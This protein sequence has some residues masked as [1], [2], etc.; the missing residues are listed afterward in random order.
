M[1][2][3]FGSDA[4]TAAVRFPLSTSVILQQR[5]VM[6]GWHERPE[7]PHTCPSELSITRACHNRKRLG[8]F[9]QVAKPSAAMSTCR[10][11]QT[12]SAVMAGSNPVCSANE[13]RFRARKGVADRQLCWASQGL[14]AS[15]IRP[16]T[17][18]WRTCARCR[19]DGRVIRPERWL[20]PISAANRTNTGRIRTD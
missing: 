9:C 20:G 10:S 4:V 7:G 3:F 11:R 6:G 1:A 12:G 16:Q 18:S 15:Q 2:A 17:G 5:R 19:W 14:C 8:S 13:P